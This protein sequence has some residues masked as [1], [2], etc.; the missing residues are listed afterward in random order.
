MKH[1]SEIISNVL[2]YLISFHKIIWD[3]YHDTFQRFIMFSWG[4]VFPWTA[5]VALGM[6]ERR[7]T[8][9]PAVDTLCTDIATSYLLAQNWTSC[10]AMKTSWKAC[11]KS[12]SLHVRYFS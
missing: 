7:R 6:C 11:F 1:F 8:N 5:V 10:N 2:Q 9:L 4:E 3:S 12:T